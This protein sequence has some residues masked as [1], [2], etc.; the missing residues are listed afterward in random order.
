MSN[1]KDR[2]PSYPDRRQF[3]LSAGAA[4]AGAGFVAHELAAV[5][6]A[7]AGQASAPQTVQIAAAETPIGPK[8]W[9]SKWGAEDQVGASNHITP[10]KVMAAAALIKTGKVYSLG[11]TYEPEMPLFGRRAFAV[12]TLR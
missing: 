1:S 6:P 7:V 4:A 5:R 12:S 2:K 10:E 8:W 11:Q 9:P 3:L